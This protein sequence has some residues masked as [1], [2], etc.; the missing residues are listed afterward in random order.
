MYKIKFFR[1]KTLLIKYNFYRITGFYKGMGFP[2][3][4]VPLVNAIIFS[5][6]E[7]GKKIFGFHDEDQMSLFEGNQII[8]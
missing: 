1:N 8:N 2:L 6:N 3:A 7:F 5:T 4:T